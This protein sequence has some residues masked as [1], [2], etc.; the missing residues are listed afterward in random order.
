MTAQQDQPRVE[1]QLAAQQLA[2]Q[3]QPAQQPDQQPRQVMMMDQEQRATAV[4][5]Q[6]DQKVDRKEG[7]LHPLP[8]EERNMEN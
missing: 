6:A 1:Q 2:A 5:R 4:Q 7:S 3:Q 8:T